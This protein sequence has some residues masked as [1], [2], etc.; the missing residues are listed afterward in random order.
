[1]IDRW[2]EISNM[3]LEQVGGSYIIASVLFLLMFLV[4][5]FITRSPKQIFTAVLFMFMFF[6]VQEGILP[7]W[8]FFL[9]ITA[10]GLII[11]K[12]II[13]LFFNTR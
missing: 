3:F 9:I 13:D 6:L 11:G 8:I 2:A 12:G 5:L 10:A 4:I 7:T 1:M